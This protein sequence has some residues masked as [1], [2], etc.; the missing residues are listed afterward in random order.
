MPTDSEEEIKGLYVSD[1]ESSTNFNVGT[2]I[3]I[4]TLPIDKIFSNDNI[5]KVDYPFFWELWYK[6]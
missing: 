5:Y 1:D 3:K 4:K 6:N 2:P